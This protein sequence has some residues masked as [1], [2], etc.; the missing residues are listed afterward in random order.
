MRAFSLNRPNLC[1]QFSFQWQPTRIHTLVGYS[2]NN[3]NIRVVL[4]EEFPRVLC[5]CLFEP[6]IFR[7]FQSA[8]F[9]EARKTEAAA[10]GAK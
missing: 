10:H 8:K 1:V 7:G 6:N 5:Q 3:I 4:R 9:H 2:V